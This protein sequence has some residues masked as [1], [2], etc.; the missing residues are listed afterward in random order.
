LYALQTQAPQG[1]NVTFKANYKQVTSVEVEANTTSKISID[2]VPPVQIAAGTYKIPISASTN[3]TSANL[4]LEA[5][6]TGTY[7]MELTTQTGLLSTDITAGD[8]KRIELLIR[9]TGSSDLFNLKPDFTAPVNWE[10]TFD[11]KKI[12]IIL[13]GKDAQVFAT[14]K[15]D[16]KAIPGDYLANF[17]VKTQ[18]VSSKATFRIS[19]K[20]R[21]LWGWIGVLIIIM[22]SG[23]VYYLFGKYGRR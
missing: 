14:I 7:S 4:E 6:I 11:P 9:N 10:V 22:A 23:S 15:A 12:D 3:E 17:E 2:I 16:K 18:E 19:V 5:V 1:W 21:M 13:T 8:K 20:T